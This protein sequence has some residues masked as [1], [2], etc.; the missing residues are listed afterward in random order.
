MLYKV[1][2]TSVAT[3]KMQEKEKERASEHIENGRIRQNA[4]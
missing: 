2:K 1:A 3:K 4:L